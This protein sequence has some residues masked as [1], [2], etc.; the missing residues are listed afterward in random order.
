MPIV[1]KKS[2]GQFVV[3]IDKGL[4]EAMELESAEVEW[5]VQSQNTLQMSVVARDADD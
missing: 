4:A 1:Q 2:N 3:T 5:T